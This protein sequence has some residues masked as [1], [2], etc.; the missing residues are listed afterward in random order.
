MSLVVADGGGEDAY[1]RE[2]TL[3]GQLTL[4]VE[5][6]AYQFPVHQVLRVIHRHPGEIAERRV[7][8][9]EVIPHPAHAGVGVKACNDGITQLRPRGQREQSK[10]KNNKRPS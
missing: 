9:I 3:Q 7:H 8:Q 6:V 5:G 10:T 2:G 1:P 4:A